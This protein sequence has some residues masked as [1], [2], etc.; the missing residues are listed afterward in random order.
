MGNT[1]S[2]IEIAFR[3]TGANQ[4]LGDIT[5]IRS[6]YADMMK[7][8]GVSRYSAADVNRLVGGGS[9]RESMSSFRTGQRLQ[10]LVVGDVLGIHSPLDGAINKFEAIQFAADRMGMTIGGLAAKFGTA[11]AGVAAFSVVLNQAAKMSKEAD[12]AWKGAGLSA[13]GI[14]GNLAVGW[15]NILGLNLDNGGAS[16]HDANLINSR[17]ADLTLGRRQENERLL[18]EFFHAPDAEERARKRLEAEVTTQMS[19]EARAALVKK[20]AEQ[21]KA[22]DEAKSH[23]EEVNKKVAAANLAD[24]N[25]RSKSDDAAYAEKWKTIREERQKMRA[26]GAKA[27]MDYA[28]K[29][30]MF[31]GL[32]EVGSAAAVKA[33]NDYAYGKDFSDT[34]IK[35][36][37]ALLAIQ[38]KMETGQAIVVGNI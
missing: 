9:A 33:A 21:E 17:Q 23:L 16:A 32:D 3:S 25:D 29:G 34:A 2:T 19:P 37:D 28:E 35:Q 30:P 36:L 11:I 38:R 13:K 8:F 14:F 18:K 26:G 1:A 12:D 31:A 22:A 27:W 20:Y 24:L 15:S 7:E 10:S 6:S 4:V 5:R